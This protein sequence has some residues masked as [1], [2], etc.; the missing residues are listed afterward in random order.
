MKQPLKEMLKKI[1]GRHLLNENKLQDYWEEIT[2]E[3]E[4]QKI[5]KFWISRSTFGPGDVLGSIFGPEKHLKSGE[6]QN[7]L[8]NFLV[9]RETSDFFVWVELS[10]RTRTSCPRKI[11]PH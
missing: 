8:M 5:G 1:G 6:I 10:R 4:G 9:F 11:L 2:N 3:M 7:F